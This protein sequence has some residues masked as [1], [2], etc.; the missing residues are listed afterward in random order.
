MKR[1]SAPLASI[2][3][4]SNFGWDAFAGPSAYRDHPSRLS[5]PLAAGVCRPEETLELRD[6]KGRVL[7]ASFQ[8]F[9]L[10]PDGSVRVWE[11]WFPVNLRRRERQTLF[12]HRAGA[13][14]SGRGDFHFQQEP[15]NFTISAVLDD[16]TRMT[17]PVVLDE[18]ASS[19][20]A[21]AAR[22]DEKEFS[23][24][25]GP[26]R[27]LFQGAIVRRMVN[28][29]PGVAL[30][31]R[32]T[33]FGPDETLKVRGVR[34]EFDLP[35]EP[36]RYGI[37]H[38]NFTAKMP[39]LTEMPTPFSVRADDG[40]VHVTDAAQLGENEAEYPSYERGAYLC[41]VDRWIGV[42]DAKSAWLLVLPDI[43]E[44]QPKAWR[45]EGRRVTLDLHPED[46]APL[47]WRQGMT[48]FQRFH[49]VRMP[50]ATTLEEFENEAQSWLR[51][52]IVRLDADVYRKA[53]WRIPFRHD[54][55]RFPKTEF[56]YR[57]SFMFSWSTGT[58]EWGDQLQGAR[59]MARNLEYDFVAVAAKEYARTGRAQLL[60]QCAASA[61]HMMY[62]DFV[63]VN[64]DPWR[65]GGI[66]AHCPRHTSGSAYPSHMWA[67]GLTL[68]HQLTGDRYAL[69]VAKRVGD[70][71]LKYIRD[72][73][74]IVDGT[75]REM[76]WTLIALS[77]IYDLTREEKYLEG[78]RRVV[79]HYLAKPA[80]DFFPTGATFTIGIAIIGFNR[81]REFHRGKE[82]RAFMLDVLDW[83]MEHRCDEMGLFHYWHD[84][85][86]GAIPYVQGHLPE[87]LN[88][89]YLLSGD[90]KY[91][92]SAFRQYEICQ[93]G[94]LITVQPRYAPP[95]CGFAAG[96]HIS[97]MG[98]LQ[99]FAEK[100]WLDAFQYAG[101]R[102]VMESAV[103]TRK[104]ATPS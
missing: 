49:L 82:T 87:A 37:R 36:T 66:P 95:E 12:V 89:G 77:A 74:H 46:S 31:V 68:Y 84:S 2:S 5:I 81:S 55:A 86:L 10:W 28:W 3:L 93:G 64:N 69:H 33:N 21:P 88:I 53:G 75:A 11:T 73:F 47:E 19:G 72:R 25:M 7:T 94:G 14:A 48:M 61:E 16:G 40:G 24:G 104:G 15:R 38:L 52:P 43:L 59:Q 27:P 39:C 50:S 91:L 35:C 22:D 60:R 101:P 57:D 83:I 8:P 99:S 67:E 76:G 80:G 56:H 103:Q 13:T 34:L 100:G 18:I 96:N 51:P 70:F 29:H 71:Y 92:R 26:R 62:T 1:D 32:L 63:V 44:R 4:E 41:A 23:L 78:I 42:A 54:P 85:E 20:A 90:E 6:E 79:D 9:L 58:F 17:Q 45:I 98:C 65:E 97:W 102:P 30:S